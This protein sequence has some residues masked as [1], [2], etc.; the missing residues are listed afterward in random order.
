MERETA[1]Q[2]D[3]GQTASSLTDGREPP[4]LLDRPIRVLQV[5]KALGSGGAEV[6]LREGFRAANPERVHLEYAYLRAKPDDLAKDLR[7][8][9][10]TVHALGAR[11]DLAMLLQGV[12]WLVRLI[13]TQQ[14]DLVH[15]HLPLAGAV[16]RLAARRCGIPCVYTEH[17]MIPRYHPM[18]RWANRLT[19]RLQDAAIAISHDVRQSMIENN[20]NGVPIYTIH[21]GV[22]CATFDRG[23]VDQERGRAALGIPKAAPVF[24]T[25]AAFRDTPA[26]RLDRWIKMA[27]AVLKAAPEA[28]A[29]LVG[30]GPLRSTLERQAHATGFAKR[31]HFAGRQ[32]DV[33]SWLAAMNVFVISSDY[34]GFGIAPAEAMAMEVPV[35]STDVSGLREVVRDGV[36]GILVPID[37]SVI[38]RLAHA[39]LSV[40]GDAQRRS[41]LAS[42]ARRHVRDSLSMSRMQRELETVY[43]RIGLT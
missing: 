9:G 8:A 36:T 24:G 17:S 19:W 32:Q 38:C 10:A 35:V 27:A 37:E 23:L 20:G 18:G 33:R 1:I 14:I 3:A 43:N 13:T 39:V 11:N 22:D 41:Q 42:N 29:I 2:V 30:D 12:G 26:K 6:L 28:H 5:I 25:V 16:A 21:N 4:S 7:A 34:E 40:L 15:A 31:I